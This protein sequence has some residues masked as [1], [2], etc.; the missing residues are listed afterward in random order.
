M[1][2]SREA[3]RQA[4]VQRITGR[5]K[6]KVITAAELLRRLRSPGG[7]HHERRDVGR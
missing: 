6:G 3:A 2:D 5:C 1:T 7:K 4:R